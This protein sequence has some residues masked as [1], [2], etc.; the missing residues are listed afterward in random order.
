MSQQRQPM[1]GLAIVVL[2]LATAFVVLASIAI[3]Q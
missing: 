3:N 2:I 1:G